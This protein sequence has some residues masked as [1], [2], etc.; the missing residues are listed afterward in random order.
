M[1]TDAMKNEYRVAVLFLAC[2]TLACLS[3]CASPDSSEGLSSVSQVTLE[4]QAVQTGAIE[5]S[6]RVALYIKLPSSYKDSPD[7]RYPVVYGLH[8]FGDDPRQ[9]VSP[10]S[11]ALEEASGPEAIFVAVDGTNRL[12][13][14]FYVN[15][16]ATGN[17]EDLVVEEVVA[18]MDAN[19]RTEPSAERR[20]LAGFSMGG[21]AAW[22]IA[23]AHPDVFGYAWSCCPGAWDANG[24]ADTLAMWDNVYRN[25]YGAAFS[26]DTS[27]GYP[28]ARVPSRDGSAADAEVVADWEKGFGGIDAKLADYAAQSSRLGGIR[29]AYAS[30]DE[31]QWISRGAQH[32]A[33][34]MLDSGLPVGIN[35]F[36]GGHAVSNAMIGQS[37]VPFAQSAFD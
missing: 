37:F 18:F 4:S 19:Y 20:M 10:F 3:A 5:E 9:M 8:G 25:A 30:S 36:A 11:N 35:G 2:V 33:Q 6:G 7:R 24:L 32:A 23:L 22:N 15:S 21:F 14:S 29:F 31:Y 34:R 12:G 17:W 27:R 13:G 16:A 1:Y 26:P 28:H